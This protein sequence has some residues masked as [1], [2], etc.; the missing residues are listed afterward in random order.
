MKLRSFFGW[1]LR[2]DN[3]WLNKNGAWYFKIYLLSN[4]RN[5]HWLV[6]LCIR[7]LFSYWGT[8]S[9]TI[10]TVIS[11]IIQDDRFFPPG[12]YVPWDPIF[13]NTHKQTP[14]ISSLTQSLCWILPSYISLSMYWCHNITTLNRYTHCYTTRAETYPPVSSTHFINSCFLPAVYVTNYFSPLEEKNK[15]RLLSG[16]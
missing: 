3:L 11:F 8:A 12:N 1:R 9:G 15:M 10:S 4:V 16:A 13:T 5:S 7:L 6:M 14:A 2:K